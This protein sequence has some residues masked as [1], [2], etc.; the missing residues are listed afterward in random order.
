MIEYFIL[1]VIGYLAFG[2][3]LAVIS[4]YL[5]NDREFVNDVIKESIEKKDLTTYKEFC[6]RYD[7]SPKSTF[8]IMVLFM[9]IAFM[10]E[11]VY[12]ILSFPSKLFKGKGK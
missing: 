5:I 12:S 6:D 1:G 10:Y 9:P 7:G 11:I 3:L 2:L 4:T 8:A